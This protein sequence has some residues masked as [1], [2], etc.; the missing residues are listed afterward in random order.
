MSNNNGNRITLNKSTSNIVRTA[1]NTKNAFTMSV[2]NLSTTEKSML[3]VLTVVV[4]IITFVLVKKKLND[5]NEVRLNEEPVFLTD[6]LPHRGNIYKEIENNGKYFFNRQS[7]NQITYSFWIYIDNSKWDENKD[8]W[9]HIMH[10]GDRITSNDPTMQMPGCWMWPNTNRLWCVIAAGTPNYGEG[11]IIDDIP[12]NKWVNVAM[13]VNRQMF[14]VYID[15]KLERTVTLFN[16]PSFGQDGS[17]HITD[18]DN[19]TTR[20]IAPAFPGAIGY[21]AYFNRA[22]TPKEIWALY[23]KYLNKVNKWT[24]ED[25]TSSDTTCV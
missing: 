7:S 3:I 18:G 12:L 15:G 19:D 8:K 4:A 10:Y 20:N 24:H 16:E 11:I 6:K 25:V 1:R 22:L 23:L 9:K 5:D 17:L 14:D 2:F 21:I 13:V